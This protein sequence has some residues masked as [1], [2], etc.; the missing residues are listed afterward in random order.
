MKQ[1]TLKQANQ[2]TPQELASENAPG[3]VVAVS[4]RDSGLKMKDVRS[5]LATL[6][7][8]SAPAYGNDNALSVMAERA[9][10]DWSYPPAHGESTLVEFSTNTDS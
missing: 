10:D 3:S 2:K 6:G 5:K 1:E 8:D 4:L 7:Y 9:K